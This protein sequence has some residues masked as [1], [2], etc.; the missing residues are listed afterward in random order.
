VSSLRRSAQ[1]ARVG[2]LKLVL[3][4]LVLVLLHR[5]LVVVNLRELVWV[6]LLIGQARQRTR[7]LRLHVPQIDL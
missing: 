4:G 6:L 1:V 2:S 3:H 5:I 7:Q